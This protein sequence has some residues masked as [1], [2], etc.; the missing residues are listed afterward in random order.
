MVKKLDYD[1]VGEQLFSNPPKVRARIERHYRLPPTDAATSS[2]FLDYAV[3]HLDQEAMDNP[4]LTQTYSNQ[5]VFKAAVNALGSNSRNW[6]SFVKVRDQH[7]EGLLYGFDPRKDAHR[8]PRRDV[9]A[10]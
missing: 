8:R 4:P 1:L 2:Q 7:L 3:R 6:A 5:Q 9:D 10:R